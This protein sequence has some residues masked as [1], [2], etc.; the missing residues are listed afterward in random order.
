MPHLNVHDILR[1]S[2]SL[3]Y[4]EQ[5]VR[6]ICNAQGGCEGGKWS[7]RT[8]SHPLLLR[9]GYGAQPDMRLAQSDVQKLHLHEAFAR[10]KQQHGASTLKATEWR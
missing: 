2:E 6:G 1:K 9:L 10:L 4:A 3:R 7:G 8:R 5:E